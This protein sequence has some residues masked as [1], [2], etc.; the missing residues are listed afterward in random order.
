[1]YM[2]SFLCT[3]W[4]HCLVGSREQSHTLRRGPLTNHPEEKT[5]GGSLQVGPKDPS[6]LV[7]APFGIPTCVCGG[8][9]C[10]TWWLNYFACNQVEVKVCNW[11]TRSK[12]ATEYFFSSLSPSL[13]PGMPWAAH[14][15]EP[16]PPA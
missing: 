14:I 13:S 10:C 7:F 3:K 4:W 6:L 1:M 2:Q 16:K 5:M 11:E 9:G 8:G 15:K 12:K